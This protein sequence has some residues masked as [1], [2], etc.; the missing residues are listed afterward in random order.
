M[1]A[2]SDR[3]WTK[4]LPL[5][6]LDMIEHEMAPRFSLE[7]LLSVDISEL[8]NPGASLLNGTRWQLAP[9]RTYTLTF[10]NDSPFAGSGYRPT[11]IT[12]RI[13]PSFFLSSLIE[14]YNDVIAP[15]TW[16][17][18]LIMDRSNPD[19]D[20]SRQ[21]AAARIVARLLGRGDDDELLQAF[22]KHIAAIRSEGV[23]EGAM[24][25]LK[26]A[27]QAG[28]LMPQEICTAAYRAKIEAAR[29]EYEG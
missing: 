9:R 16:I 27:H 14:D 24:F 3:D 26:L 25:Y 28:E 4:M 21:A 5:G 13:A 18:R 1:I 20:Y 11:T 7:T 15:N 19:P 10:R 12:Q 17:N 2:A 6:L 22:A 29:K 8:V 23:E